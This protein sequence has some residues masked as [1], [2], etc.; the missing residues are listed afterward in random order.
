MGRIFTTFSLMFIMIFISIPQ[1][2]S[3]ETNSDNSFYFIQ[4]TD[5]HL[6]ENQ[7]DQNFE[8]IISK[9][10]NLPMKI[11]LIVHTGDIISEQIMDNVTKKKIAGELKKL[12]F[13]VYFVPGNHDINDNNREASLTAYTN[14]FSSLNY[15]VDCR[16]VVFIFL[17]SEPIRLSFKIAGY[18]P[19]E[20]LSNTL[21]KNKD[22]PA[23]I[24]FHAPMTEDFYN[25]S[26]HKGWTGNSK[27]E[28]ENL[29]GNYGNIKAI[30]NGHFHRD[31]LHWT[32]G[33]PVYVCESVA[34]Y[35][36][37]QPAFRIY[38]YINGRLDYTTQY[39]E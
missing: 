4:I 2:I 7:N 13:P 6:G 19:M 15:T 26:G 10:N 14:I 29:I 39:L 22:K 38:H 33:I 24:C 12:K 5:T 21:M 23:I 36:N 9:I 17:Y 28:W 1:L 25:N 31:E 18:K 30:L 16:G 35:W 37:R 27:E 3:Q 34:N 11:E 32:V 20:W 8:K